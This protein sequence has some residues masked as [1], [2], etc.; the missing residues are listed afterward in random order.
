MDDDIAAAGDGERQAV[1]VGLEQV[2]VGDIGARQVDAIMGDA[3]VGHGVEAQ[4][5]SPALERPPG[6]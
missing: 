4:D 6:W 3:G 5:I 2:G 1:R